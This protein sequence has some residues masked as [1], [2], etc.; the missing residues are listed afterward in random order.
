MPVIVVGK[1]IFNKL[2]YFMKGVFIQKNQNVNQIEV[3]DSI[4]A[5]DLFAV[6]Y[7]GAVDTRGDIS[8]LSS[9]K[10]LKF[11][12]GGPDAT[13]GLVT[14]SAGSKVVETSSFQS[15]SR[16]LCFAQSVGAS[17]GELSITDK[18]NGVSF[19]ISS[20]SNGDDRDVYWIILDQS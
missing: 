4:T 8:L 1:N 15:T 18:I 16:V 19:T 13:A 3:R 7:S 20:D 5:Q 9:G 11:K 2:A 10:T 17:R 6:R 14:L 12:E